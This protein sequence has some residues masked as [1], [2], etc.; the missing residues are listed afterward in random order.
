VE[1]IT[2][3]DVIAS[4]RKEK[5]ITGREV[6]ESVNIKT[7]YLSQLENGNRPIT[8]KNLFRIATALGTTPA[9]LLFETLVKK[10][11]AKRSDELI[12]EEA[13]PMILKMLKLIAD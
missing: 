10:K 1:Q 3:G 12:F 7:S 6:A 5:D 2:L 9:D 13:K 8:I 11:Q 4:L